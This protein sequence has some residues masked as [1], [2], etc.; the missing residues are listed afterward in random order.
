MPDVVQHSGRKQASVALARTVFQRRLG[1]GRTVW[2][3][4]CGASHC[5]SHSASSSVTPTEPGTFSASTPE[6]ILPITMMPGEG[7]AW[8]SWR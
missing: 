5:R 3:P 4:L 2:F 1:T 8:P 6:S 7:T